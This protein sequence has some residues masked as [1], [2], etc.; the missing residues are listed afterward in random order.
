[1]P[2]EGSRVRIR[3]IAEGVHEEAAGTALSFRSDRLG[4]LLLCPATRGLPHRCPRHQE[5]R[6]PAVGSRESYC[7]RQTDAWLTSVDIRLWRE[8]FMRSCAIVGHYP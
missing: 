7:V 8:F 3:S 4:S 2:V 5:R 1:M 6:E